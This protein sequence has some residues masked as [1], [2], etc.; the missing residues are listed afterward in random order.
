MWVGCSRERNRRERREWNGNWNDDTN[1]QNHTLAYI[2]KKLNHLSNCYSLPLVFFFSFF[3]IIFHAL[4]FFFLNENI[5]P[6]GTS[7]AFLWKNNKSSPVKTQKIFQK[8]KEKFYRVRQQK[9]E[10]EMRNGWFRFG[11]QWRQ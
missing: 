7:V 3:A 4:Y 10:R 8:V 2:T 11:Q 6:A 9:Q 1:G 5:L